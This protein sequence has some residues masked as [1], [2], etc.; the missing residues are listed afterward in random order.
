M[1]EVKIDRSFIHDLVT[2]TTDQSIVHATIALAH[3]LGF[4]V[5]AE[6]VEDETTLTHLRRMG[7]DLAQGFHLCRPLP[8]HELERE[9]TTH[10]AEIASN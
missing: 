5:V 9:L 1:N 2:D 7:C 8:A 4:A 3:S 6:G 10:F